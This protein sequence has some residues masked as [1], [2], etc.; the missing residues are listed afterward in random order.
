MPRGKGIETMIKFTTG[1]SYGHCVFKLGNNHNKKIKKCGKIG[2][3][4]CN[5][6][7]VCDEHYKI[8][9]FNQKQNGKNQD[10]YQE[11]F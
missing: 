9:K 11:L 2:V 4:K 3:M 10:I 6:G 7:Y 8:I 5:K 1:K